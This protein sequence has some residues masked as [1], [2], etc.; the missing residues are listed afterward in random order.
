M[1][2]VLSPPPSLLASVVWVRGKE[3]IGR[4]GRVRNANILIPKS[5]LHLLYSYSPLT[6]IHGCGYE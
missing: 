2:L 3:D 6:Y 4:I 1:H 5:F